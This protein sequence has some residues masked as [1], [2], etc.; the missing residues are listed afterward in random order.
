MKK[1]FQ[2]KLS[3]FLLVGPALN[4]ALK[5]G[6]T[7]W[8]ILTLVGSILVLGAFVVGIVFSLVMAVNLR[9]LLLA[10]II[11]YYLLKLVSFYY[12]FQK[13]KPNQLTKNNFFTNQTEV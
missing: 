1:N 12:F 11:G 6:D 13:L 7:K 3:I 10:T 5:R 2:T 8:V 9:Y 4:L